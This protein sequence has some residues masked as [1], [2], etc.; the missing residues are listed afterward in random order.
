MNV[1]LKRRPFLKRLCKSYTGFRKLG[2]GPWDALRWAWR[3]AR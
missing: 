3:V 1:E 2:Y